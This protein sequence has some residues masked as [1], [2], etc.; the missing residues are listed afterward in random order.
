MEGVRRVGD[1]DI[2]GGI[3]SAESRTGCFEPIFLM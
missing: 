1:T 2:F 3:V